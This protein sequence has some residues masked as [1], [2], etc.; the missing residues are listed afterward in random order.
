MSVLSLALIGC[1]PPIVL[2]FA[3]PASAARVVGP[4]LEVVGVVSAGARVDLVVTGAAPGEVVHFGGAAGAGGAGPCPAALGGVCLELGP[5]AV[6]LGSAAADASGVATLSVT[7]PAAI[8][9]NPVLV[10]QAAIVRGA[11]GADSVTTPAV[12][13][14][15]GVV[16]WDADGLVDEVEVAIGS[17][18][19]LADTDGDGLTDL[20]ELEPH[21][22]PLSSD[23]DGDGVSDASDVCLAGDDAADADADTVADA[24]DRCPGDPDP[25]QQDADGDGLGDACDRPALVAS[26]WSATGATGEL[27]TWSVASAGDVDGDGFEDLLVGAPFAGP[28][29]SADGEASLYAGSPNGPSAAPA[30][31]VVSTE[32]GATLGWSLAGAGDVDGDGFDDVIVGM[33]HYN[34][35]ARGGA[36]LFSGSA[37]GLSAAPSWIARGG[38]DLGGF[39][40]AVASAGDVNGDGYADVVVGSLN[41]GLVRVYHGSSAG[42]A[43]SPDWRD[44]GAQ[45]FGAAVASAGDVDGDGFDDL[46][47]GAPGPYGQPTSAVHLYAGSAAGLS[48]DPVWTVVGGRYFGASVASGDLN[49]DGHGDLVVGSCEVGVDVF[50]GS[51]LGPAEAPDWSVSASQ[52]SYFGCAVAAG[53]VDGDGFGDVVVGSALQD[54]GQRDEGVALVWLGSASGLA[55]ASAWLGESNQRGPGPYDYSSDPQYGAAVGA[56]DFDGDGRSDVVV[57]AHGYDTAYPTADDGRAFLYLGRAR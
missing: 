43:P 53:D 46:L 21:L 31:S 37:A 2:G 1:A 22:D 49:G 35:M 40:G 7:V 18:P 38:A 30:W 32:P 17:D 10:V 15:G 48:A 50:L 52:I 54:N 39:G 36:A 44:S 55:A 33:P 19:T 8:P 28:G 3:S 42:L 12:V 29:F 34:H 27:F 11:A 41:D 57:G 51:L 13:L 24:C 25:S 26:A 47:V 14:D 20:A 56:G 6:A 5:G 9:P 23:A 45:G 16:D 4:E